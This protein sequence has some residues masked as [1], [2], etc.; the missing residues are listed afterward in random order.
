M[1]FLRFYFPFFF[2]H[3][4]MELQPGR[5]KT[6]IISALSNNPDMKVQ[7]IQPN[8]VL[9]KGIVKFNYKGMVKTYNVIFVSK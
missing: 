2:L 3:W 9:G 4:L 5:T 6:P 7:V 1:D 8:T